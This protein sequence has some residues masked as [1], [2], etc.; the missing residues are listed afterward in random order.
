M[1]FAPVLLVSY[2]AVM[3]GPAPLFPAISIRGTGWQRWGL[4]TP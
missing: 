3:I 2:R 1:I 4:W